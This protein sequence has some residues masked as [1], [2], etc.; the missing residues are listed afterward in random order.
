M[1]PL[2]SLPLDDDIVDQ[3]FTLCPDFETLHALTL[4]CKALHAV[5]STHPNSINTA[6]TRNLIGPA[7]PE[8]LKHIRT[9]FDDNYGASDDE[10][11]EGNTPDLRQ[12][13]PSLITLAERT[14]LRKNAVVV[15]KLEALFSRWYRSYILYCPLLIHYQ[16]QR[17]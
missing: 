6:V 15:H 2:N 7:F 12:S 11:V 14:A 8:A 16:V 17:S 9:K 3:I 4:V 13:E 1:R 5:F 10:S